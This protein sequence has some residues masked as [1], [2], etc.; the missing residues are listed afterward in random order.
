MKLGEEPDLPVFLKPV[1]GKW[2]RGISVWLGCD[3]ALALFAMFAIAFLFA[4]TAY[5]TRKIW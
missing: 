2:L 3:E 5:Q 1:R 4:V